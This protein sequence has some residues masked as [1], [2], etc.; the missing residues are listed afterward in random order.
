[1]VKKEGHERGKNR[2]KG[3]VKKGRGIFLTA[4]PCFVSSA[5]FLNQQE[6]E[7]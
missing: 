1:M 2:K 5:H 4:T 6:T 3:R 7:E